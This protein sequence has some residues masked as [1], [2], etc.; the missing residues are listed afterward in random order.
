M[1]TTHTSGDAE[2]LNAQAELLRQVE[3]FK[4]VSHADLV[5]LC[6]SVEVK[7]YTDGTVIFAQGDEGDCVYVIQEGAV[8]ILIQGR[9][10]EKQIS[11]CFEGEIVGELALLDGQPRSAKAVA[12]G[13]VSAIVI[14]RE[15]FINFLLARPTMM[16]TLL[17]ELT[18]RARRLS[19]LVEGNI[20]WLG[21]LARGEFEHATSFAV[22]LAPAMFKVSPPRPLIRASAMRKSEAKAATSTSLFKLAG[23]ALEKRDAH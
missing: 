13:A 22:R 1:F 15:T 14:R 23:S 5:A 8:K 6:Q 19:D 17:E 16:L 9:E 10:G 2:Q 12:S 3:L 21:K 4:S 20:E 18:R 11:T 7:T